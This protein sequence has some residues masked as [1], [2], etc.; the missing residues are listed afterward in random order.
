[1]SKVSV[2]V[3]VHNTEK[4]LE[5]CVNS[6]T[7]QTLKDIEIILVENAS[8][9]GSL[10]K[11]KECAERDSRISVLSYEYGD[12]SYARNRGVEAAH[13]EYVAFVDSDDTLYQEA[14][15]LLLKDSFLSLHNLL[16]QYLHLKSNFLYLQNQSK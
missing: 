13:S 6:I 9:D 14:V 2:I 10:Q 12:L 1:M 15:N 4:Y 3:P 5:K 16:K 8:D 11:C 7:S